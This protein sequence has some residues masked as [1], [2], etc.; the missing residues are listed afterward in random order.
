LSGYGASMG[1][2]STTFLR[3]PVSTGWSLPAAFAHH[4]PIGSECMVQTQ[5]LDHRRGYQISTEHLIQDKYH[6]C[7]CP[8]GF[9]QAPVSSPGPSMAAGQR[10]W[11]PI[12]S[13]SSAEAVAQTGHALHEQVNAG[14][15]ARVQFTGRS[16]EI[17][18]FNPG[19][20]NQM[21]KAPHRD[22]CDQTAD[23]LMRTSHM[24]FSRNM[25]RH[26]R[27]IL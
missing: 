8:S 17:K 12:R 3:P 15:G 25:A 9:G 24:Q 20:E 13:P 10:L 6:H 23:A 22:F 4:S 5:N 7:G 2:W 18:N 16:G 11:D 21:R 1:A 26:E 14:V 19:Y 27:S